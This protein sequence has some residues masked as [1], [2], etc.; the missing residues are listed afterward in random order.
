MESWAGGIGRGSLALQELLVPSPA[1]GLSGLQ[2]Q[3]RKPA[4]GAKHLVDAVCAWP[5]GAIVVIKEK[6]VE[7]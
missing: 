3:H 7:D 2:S 4:A 5:Q 1:S 6:S